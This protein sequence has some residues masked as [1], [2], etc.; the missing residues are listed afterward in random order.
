LILPRLLRPDTTPNDQASPANK[1]IH[2]TPGKSYSRVRRTWSAPVNLAVGQ[3][4]PPQ[5]PHR[6]ID[7]PMSL[8]EN[9]MKIIL[10]LTILAIFSLTN[11][12]ELINDGVYRARVSFA[13]TDPNSLDPNTEIRVGG[14]TKFRVINNPNQNAYMIRFVNVYRVQ[15][16]TATGV[17]YAESNVVTSDIYKLNKKSSSN[18]PI[19]SIV[20]PSASGL[21]SG[22]LIVPF[23]FRLN[24]GTISGDATVGYY[25][26]YGFDLPL[27]DKYVTI[28][29]ILSAGLSQVTVFD[30]NTDKSQSKSAATWATGLLIQNWDKINIGLVYGQDR[31]G[32]RNWEYEGDGW[33]S[34]SFGWAL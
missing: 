16:K 5:I 26:G 11:A 1:A 21:T 19:E 18:I 4:S 28:T 15:S 2:R 17:S 9:T 10:I 33:I 20:E 32:D 13:V 14:Q 8:P 24:D 12:E 6:T 29:P 34:I 25:A 22:P 30:K 7:C 3:K 27:G 31:I 23:K